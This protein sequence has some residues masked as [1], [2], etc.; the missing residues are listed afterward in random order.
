MQKNT[1]WF[2][3]LW[4]FSAG[5][6]SA[7]SSSFRSCHGFV[8]VGS[9]CYQ[10]FES[11]LVQMAKFGAL[12]N[13]HCLRHHSAFPLG[14]RWWDRM[15]AGNRLPARPR[16]GWE[17]LEKNIKYPSHF[18]FL[19]LNLQ[20]SL[21]AIFKSKIFLGKRLCVIHFAS[22]CHSK[23][24]SKIKGVLGVVA[25]RCHHLSSQCAGTMQCLG[26]ILSEE[27]PRHSIQYSQCITQYLRQTLISKELS[28][29]IYFFCLLCPSWVMTGL[30]CSL[31]MRWKD[32]K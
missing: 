6:F 20:F 8:H 15:G 5:D 14:N 3:G 2:F 13:N 9:S 10:L 31:K 28:K 25:V 23:Q 27:R 12:G 17:H 1:G 30:L 26:W 7:F 18:P 16:W 19:T 21:R 22:F 11:D 24:Y 29:N 4:T 32:S